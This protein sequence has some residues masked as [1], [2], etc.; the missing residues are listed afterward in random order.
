MPTWTDNQIC[1]GGQL[2]LTARPIGVGNVFVSTTQHHLQALREGTHR[3]EWRDA[4]LEES[5]L[6]ARSLS[7]LSEM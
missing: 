1:H 4:S 2:D 6:I 3:G 7:Y 5:L